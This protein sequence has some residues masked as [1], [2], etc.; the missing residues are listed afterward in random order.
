MCSSEPFITHI[1]ALKQWEVTK[2]WT[3]LLIPLEQTDQNGMC[4]WGWAR[5]KGP[6]WDNNLCGEGTKTLKE[7]SA[8]NDISVIVYSSSMT[9]QTNTT[10]FLLW[11]TKNIYFFVHAM[12]LYGVQ[13]ALDTINFHCMG[14]KSY[15]VLNRSNSNRLGM[16]KV[17]KQWKIKKCHFEWN[18][19]LITE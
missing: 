18:I 14:E 11:N 15:Y 5:K 10:Y 16:T 2:S 9:F 1:T 19:P 6:V 17:S 12:K 8:K 7:S 13:I 3:S 4:S